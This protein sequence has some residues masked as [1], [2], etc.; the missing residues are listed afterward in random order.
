MLLRFP[1]KNELENVVRGTKIKILTAGQKTWCFIEAFWKFVFLPSQ[2]YCKKQQCLWF[3]HVFLC[4]RS[5]PFIV[6]YNAF[7]CFFKRV[8]QIRV[9][10]IGMSVCVFDIGI[11]NDFKHFRPKHVSRRHYSMARCIVFYNDLGRLWWF[12][13]IRT[14][15]KHMCFTIHSWLF[16][17]LMGG[18]CFSV[19]AKK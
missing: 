16:V 10:L 19:P 5:A 18:S 17:W 13:N 11:Y 7:S 8:C 12:A 2:I 1:Y 3:G 9:A 4:A 15:V 14:M 6:F